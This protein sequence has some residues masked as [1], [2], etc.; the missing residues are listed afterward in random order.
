MLGS[1]IPESRR[2]RQVIFETAD[3]RLPLILAV[4]FHASIGSDLAGQHAGVN[5][6]RSLRRRERVTEF[7]SGDS[8]PPCHNSNSAA[9]TS[10][11][12][13]RTG[14]TSAS[15]ETTAEVGNRLTG[16]PLRHPLLAKQR[17]SPTRP[18]WVR[19]RAS[20]I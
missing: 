8:A 20:P 12:H 16:E 17:S 11:P 6:E 10:N 9:T 19:A 14:R 18:R 13:T 1:T 5:V 15:L 7:G 3:R 2:P 4:R